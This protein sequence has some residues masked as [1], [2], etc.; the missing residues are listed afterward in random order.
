MEILLFLYVIG[1]LSSSVWRRKG[2]TKRAGF[3]VGFLL[4]PLGL[5]FVLLTAPSK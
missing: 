4:G 3:W 1:K 5:A 2:G